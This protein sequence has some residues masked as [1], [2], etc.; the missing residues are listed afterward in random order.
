MIAQ[1]GLHQ[2]PHI[3]EVETLRLSN[4]V[5]ANRQQGEGMRNL[6]RSTHRYP[7][8]ARNRHLSG[9]RSG[10][11]RSAWFYPG[12][13]MGVFSYVDMIVFFGAI[14]PTLSVI[15]RRLNDMG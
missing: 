14:L 8:P 6:G 12:S 15:V 2:S 1:G 7:K 3:G 4:N 13:Q 10:L 5:L 9:R 11:G